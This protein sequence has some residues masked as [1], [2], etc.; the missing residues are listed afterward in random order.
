MSVKYCN[1]ICQKKHWPTHKKVCKRRAA[2]LHDEAL[3]K[4]PPPKEDCPI[5]FL[6]MPIK[7]VSCISLPSATI[8]SV[9]INDYAKANME[10]AAEDMEVYYPCCG[11]SICRECFYSFG[12]SRKMK[13]PFCNSDNSNK[14]AEETIQEMMKRVEVNDAG[15]MTALGRYYKH[16]CFKIGRKQ[17]NFY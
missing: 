6:P 1:G 15:A 11:K 12:M 17:K 7:L 2:E 4:D 3:F 8:S 10:L 9:P 16:V 13:C 5:C 14:T